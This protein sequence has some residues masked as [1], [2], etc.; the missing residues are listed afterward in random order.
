MRVWSPGK[1]GECLIWRRNLIVWY[2]C[3]NILA[4]LAFLLRSMRGCD[5]T[6]HEYWPLIGWH[7]LMWQ[8]TELWLVEAHVWGCDLWR[9]TL[10]NNTWHWYLTEQWSDSS[11]SGHNNIFNPRLNLVNSVKSWDI[12]S[13]NWVKHEWL[14][15]GENSVHDNR[16]QNIYIKASFVFHSQKKPFWVVL[17]YFEQAKWNIVKWM[18]NLKWL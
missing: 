17:L 8:N 1:C 11:D 16:K 13:Q 6:W 9:S 18:L 10:W 5:V 15:M 12:G 7:N 3:Y 2:Y 14:E 4:F